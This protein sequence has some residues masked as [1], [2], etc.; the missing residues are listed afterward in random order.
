MAS[1]AADQ[2]EDGIDAVVMTGAQRIDHVNVLAVVHLLG[3]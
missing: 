3:P 2:L 1:G